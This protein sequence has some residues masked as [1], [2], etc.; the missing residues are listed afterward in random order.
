M[1]KIFKCL[2]ILLAAALTACGGGGGSGGD[3]A[4]RYTI[5]LRSD[6]GQLPINIS[7]EGAGIGAYARYTSTLYVEAREGTAPIPGGEEVFGC[8]IVQGL[9]S[10]ALY[11]LDG[12]DEHEDDDGNPLAYRAVTLDANS[13]GASFHLHSGTKA[14]TVRITCSVTDPRDRQVYST[15]V[16][17]VVGAATGKPAS[18]RAEV[19]AP[20]YLG[21]LSNTAGLRNNVAIQAFLMDDANQPVP[22]PTAANMQV[23]IRP[24]GASAGARL[25]SGNQSGS[26]LQVRTIGGMG[27]I[28]LSSGES[29][30]SI[31]LEYT[32]DRFD[33]NVSNGIQDPVVSLQAVGVHRAVATVPLAIT[34]SAEITIANGLPFA[35]A[36]SAEG[37]IPPYTWSSATALPTGL[38]LDSDGVISGTPRAAPGKYNVVVR[39]TDSIGNVVSRNLVLTVEGVVIDPLSF[40]V[41][42]CSGDV[43]TACP[44]PDATT[45]TPYLYAF[46]ATGGDPAVAITWTFVPAPP[47]PWLTTSTAGANG[48]ISTNATPIPPAASCLKFF[49]TATRGTLSVTRQVSIRVNGGVCP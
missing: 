24:F 2:M 6:K 32:T 40:V 25:L 16:D 23:S 19:Q 45:G 9:D 42:G 17:V 10:G 1:S 29:A 14:G 4:L 5:T 30:G 49:V 28:S 3:S 27:L 20:K 37:G 21:T 44:L 48:V 38:T 13:G 46:S 33:N 47:A 35:Y 41:N 18:V 31:L 39:V 15:S 7:N 11:Y 12:D 34:G 43:N 36:L 8:A 26:V 22:D